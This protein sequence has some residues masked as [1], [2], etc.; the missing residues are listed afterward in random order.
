MILNADIFYSKLMLFGEYSV[1]MGSMA[2]SVPYGHFRGELSFI[3]EDKTTDYNF[4]VSSNKVLED[5][6]REVSCNSRHLKVAEIID[7]EQLGHD[8]ENGLYFESTIPQGYGLGSSGAL[9]AAVYS[10]YSLTPR[11]NP[12]LLTPGELAHLRNKLACL[13]SYFHG[14][15]SGIDP[16]SCY[17]KFPL[18]IKSPENISI[19]GLPRNKIK[20]KGGIF[21][22][23]TG[24]P[25]KTE[26]L[27]NEFLR[28][29]KDEK[30]FSNK[31]FNN[32]IPWTNNCILS[33]TRGDIREFTKNLALL[34]RFQLKTM[35]DMIP[36]G[37]AEVW[38]EGIRS[39]D[40]YLKL[41]GSGGG[42][43]ILGFAEKLEEVTKALGKDHQVIT[44]YKSNGRNA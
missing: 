2:L 22:I 21:L 18:L 27:V 37:Y 23:N 30:D 29:M 5:F 12:R 17:T 24:K 9:T 1:I 42:G 43:F 44:V 16:L 33:L 39:R 14:S 6:Q 38:E 10:K 8:I 34:S 3:N 41:C 36:K 13:E 11:E 40:Y 35:K 4:A 19:V 31:I 28:K 25:R 7:I 20:T 32:F 15:S 26:H